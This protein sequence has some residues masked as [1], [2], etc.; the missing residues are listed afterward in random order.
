MAETFDKKTYDNFIET[1]DKIVKDLEENRMQSKEIIKSKPAAKTLEDTEAMSTSIESGE[2]E[3][4]IPVDNTAVTLTASSIC[5]E[6]KDGNK[7]PFIN[8]PAAAKHF[9]INPTTVRTR[10]THNKVDS[11]GNTWSYAE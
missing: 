11:D 2:N 7:L 5:V 1:V 8:A 9:N 3:M 4:L 6:D 10:C